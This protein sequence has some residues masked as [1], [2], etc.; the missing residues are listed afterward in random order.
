MIDEKNFIEA[1]KIV[2]NSEKIVVFTGAGASTESG[3]ADF[4]SEGVCGLATILRFMRATTI[5][6]KTRAS[7]GLCITN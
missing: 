7:S 5:F 6:W 4:R 2:K 3:I 1:T